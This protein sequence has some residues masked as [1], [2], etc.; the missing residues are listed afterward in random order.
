ML[1]Q[2]EKEPEREVAQ[3]QTFKQGEDVE[4]YV[5]PK[6][7][8]LLVEREDPE[9]EEKKGESTE[10]R[11]RSPSPSLHIKKKE[12]SHRRETSRGS[13]RSRASDRGVERVFKP[14]NS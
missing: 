4:S 14:A 9:E 11:G 8:T 10:V 1:L 13:R 2:R 7:N 3:S 12:E 6:I 5:G